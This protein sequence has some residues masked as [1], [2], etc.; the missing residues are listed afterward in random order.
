MSTASPRDIIAA[1][2]AYAD[3][4]YIGCAHLYRDHPE[5]DHAALIDRLESEFDGWALHASATAESMA[6]CQ[7]W[8]EWFVDMLEGDQATAIVAACK[9][10]R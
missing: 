1:R 5:V 8:R 9:A 2:I 7:W 6:A 4:P 10:I 3:P